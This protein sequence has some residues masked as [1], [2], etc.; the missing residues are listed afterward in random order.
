[1]TI[2]KSLFVRSPFSPLQSHMEKVAGCVG[3]AKALYD[4]YVAGDHER[5]NQLAE[6]ISELEH[7]ADLTK[8]EI[9]NNL[10]SGLF[11]A[12][13]RGDFLEILALQD[14]I[15]DRCEDLAVLFT[16]KQL[17]PLP[18][19]KD[20]LRAFLDKNIEAVRHTHS[21]IREMDELVQSSFG[22]KEAEK[23]QTMVDE[24]AY[25]EHEADVLQRQLMKKLYSMD[26]NLPY[27][28]F[29]LWINIMQVI[30]A[31]SNVSE[32][33]ANRVRMLLEIKK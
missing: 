14:T 17:E 26:S 7:A 20:D 11:L 29:M 3:K 24:V 18:E 10:R 1:M 30:A 33:L 27:S 2:I 22:G 4:A 21:I 32:K 9:R 13:N 16:L 25:M 6:E 28:S 5:M 8:N 23:V 12:I 15:A 31:L 19:L